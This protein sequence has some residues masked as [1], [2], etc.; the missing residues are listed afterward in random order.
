MATQVA[1]A[2]QSAVLAVLTLSGKITVPEIVVLSIF[3]GLINAFDFPVRQSMVVQMIE[4]RKDLPNAIALNSS[5]VNLA[6]LIGPSFAGILIALV[7]EGGCFAIDAASY[8]AVI[9]TLL[10]MSL[11]RHVSQ[12]TKGQKKILHELKEGF[13]YAKNSREILSVL[14][15]LALISFMGVPYMTLLPMVVSQQL[16][17]DART[18]GYL[19]AASGLG[20]F[21]GALFLASRKTVSVLG[22]VACFGAITFGLGLIFFGFSHTIWFSL[23]MMFFAGLGMMIQASSSNTILQTLVPE[24]KRGRVMSM[25]IMAYAGMAPFGSLLGGFLADRIGV[26]L[27]L[28]LGG[29]ACCFGGILFLRTLPEI[30]KALLNQSI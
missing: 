28:E 21:F 1:A 24:S 5:M 17:G 11:P 25:F 15:L 9:S 3:Q 8:L 30:R 19:T 4:D 16:S 26:G 22:S 10:L 13:L 18:L 12:K 2:L 29:I 14:A 20:A 6:R 7:G 27:T 23:P